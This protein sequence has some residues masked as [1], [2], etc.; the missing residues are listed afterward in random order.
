MYPE[1]SDEFAFVVMVSMIL[2][3]WKVIDI[4]MWIM[5]HVDLSISF[6]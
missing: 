1:I 4:G 6:K 2:A 5:S 3:F